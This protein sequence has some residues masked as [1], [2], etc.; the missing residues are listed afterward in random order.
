MGC[1]IHERAPAQCREFDCRESRPHAARAPPDRVMGRSRRRSSMPEGSGW[2][3]FSG[4]SSSS[5]HCTKNGASCGKA[6]LQ[7]QAPDNGNHQKETSWFKPNF[8]IE[9][10][11]FRTEEETAQQYFFC[12]LSVRSLAAKSAAVLAAMNTAPLFWITTHHAML[13]SAI[14]ALGAFSTKAQAPPS[15]PSTLGARFPGGHDQ[16]VLGTRQSPSEDSDMFR[17]PP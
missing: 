6:R 1:T 7:S 16:R 10:E 12:Y 4:S 17:F 3:R 14:I 15:R 9:L 13:L 8:E 5:R 2:R 11:V